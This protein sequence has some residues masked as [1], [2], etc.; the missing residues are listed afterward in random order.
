MHV[1]RVL[2]V[3]LKFHLPRRVRR[4]DFEQSEVL[5]FVFKLRDDRGQVDRLAVADL[6]LVGYRRE[7]ADVERAAV[8]PST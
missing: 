5:A 8:N 6:R 7:R 2:D 4:Q 3:G 1:R